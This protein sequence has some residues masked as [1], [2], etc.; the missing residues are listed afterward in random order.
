MR[1]YARE[2]AYCKIYAYFISG[3]FDG[4]FSQF[5]ASKLTEEDVAFATELVEG[6][7]ANKSQLE[8]TVASFSRGFKLRRIYLPDL[9]ALCMA[10]FEMQSVGTPHPV[11]INEAVG[12]VKKYSTEKSVSFVNGILAAYSRSVNNG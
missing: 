11:A 3:E 7:S 4:D 9:A 1:S 5:D 12:I 10:I 6:V 2:A 8:E